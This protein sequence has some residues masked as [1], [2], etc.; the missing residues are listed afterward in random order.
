MKKFFHVFFL[1]IFLT[2]DICSKDVLLRADSKVK[3]TKF[4]TRSGEL[5]FTEKYQNING[6]ITENW[7]VNE[8]FVSKDDYYKKIIQS[9]REE[10]EIKR[11]QEILKI[12]E[13]EKKQK[14]FLAQKEKEKEE[15]LRETQIQALRKLVCIELETVEKSLSKLNKYKVE[16]Y[17]VYQEDTFPSEESFNDVKIELINQ[18]R[19]LTLRNTDELNQDELKKVLS[20][21]EV[22]PDKI[23]RFFRQSVKYAINQCN[24][25]KKLKELLSLI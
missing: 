20:K 23:E 25:T 11:E 10:E 16:Q 12:E 7:I 14:E 1:F 21:L 3:Q 17:F 18:A 5:V 9:E 4:V 19:E 2:L 6:K 13:E 22:I 8:V 24:D 15:F